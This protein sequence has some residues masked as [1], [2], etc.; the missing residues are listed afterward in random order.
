MAD[1]VAVLS[2]LMKSPVPKSKASTSSIEAPLALKGGLL[3]PYRA[4]SWLAASEAAEKDT[5]ASETAVGGSSVG[6]PG[7][8]IRWDFF[9]KGPELEATVVKVPATVW[10]GTRAF[11]HRLHDPNGTAMLPL[12]M[13][14][15]R[16]HR[17]LCLWQRSHAS[18][19]DR[20][21]VKKV[22]SVET[23]IALDA[24]PYWGT[25]VMLAS[26]GGHRRR[27]LKMTVSGRRLLCCPKGSTGN[28]DI[29]PRDMT[30][31]GNSGHCG[32]Y[33]LRV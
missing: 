12:T 5:V 9:L 16:S 30:S 8:T 10:Q 11:M 28:L 26:G 4:L 2:T 17:S 29:S 31:V 14:G 7:S 25:G 27:V 6:P 1:D 21:A 23:D 19:R 33:P 18:R 22:S 32:S 3:A 13:T 24:V 15:L 20:A